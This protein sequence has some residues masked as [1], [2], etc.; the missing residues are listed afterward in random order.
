[1]AVDEVRIE[2]CG[3]IFWWSVVSLTVAS[4]VSGQCSASSVQFDGGFVG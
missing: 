3:L 1:M 4:L 2:R